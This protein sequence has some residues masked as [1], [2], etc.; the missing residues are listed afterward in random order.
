MTAA[1]T[2][3]SLQNFADDVRN[4]LTAPRKHIPCVY[5]YDNHAPR[6]FEEI[7]RQP[8]YDHEDYARLQAVR[9]AVVEQ[10]W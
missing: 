8:E 9:N 4:G 7:R 2:A 3:I 10:R 6:F 1:D 5:C